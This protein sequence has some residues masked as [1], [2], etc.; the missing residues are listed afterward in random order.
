MNGKIRLAFLSLI[1]LQAIHSAEEFIFRFYEKF[2]PMKLLYQDA[3]HLAKPA[4]LIS[5]A[6]LFCA[7]LMCLY[8]W[9][10]PARKGART[11]IWVWLII[12]SFNVIAHS[13]WAV[14][15]RGYNPGL[16]TATLFVP[17]LIYL[18]YCM[19]RVPREA[20]A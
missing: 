3:P 15:I 14:L 1:L 2:P 13:V 17:V 16:A 18:S 4:F 12:E 10:W 7:G 11:I 9:V 20:V 8:Y 6:L 19:R 5:N